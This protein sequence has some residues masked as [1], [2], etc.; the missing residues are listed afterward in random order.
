MTI[1]QIREG[2]AIMKPVS[3]RQIIRYLVQLNI[4][5]EGIRQRPQHYPHNAASLILD[6]LGPVNP[7]RARNTG[8]AWKTPRAKVAAKLP[9]MPQLRAERQKARGK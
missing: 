6:A 9:T 3:R 5:P 8:T 7:M 1:D 4:K 2:V